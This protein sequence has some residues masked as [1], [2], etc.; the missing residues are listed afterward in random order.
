MMFRG[1]AILTAMFAALS[2]EPAQ[3]D[4][5]LDARLRS[6]TQQLLNALATGDRRPWSEYLD[7]RGAFTDENGARFGK[8]EMVAQVTPLPHG[9]SGHIDI[10][11]WRL[12]RWGDV[13]VDTHVDDEFEDFHGQKLHAAYRVTD[14]WVREPVG[15]RLIASQTIAVQQDPPQAA[16]PDKVLQSYVGRYA[17][18]SDYVYEISREG[19]G[20]VGRTNG[21]K[22][23][24]LRP[25]LEDVLFTPGQPRV[26]KIFQRDGA[27]RVTGFV[28]RREERDVAFK[29][30]DVAAQSPIPKGLAEGVF[31]ESCRSRFM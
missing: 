18:G 26:R 15:W 10:V 13:A 1:S 11:D 7:S 29:R 24:A 19:S 12:T 14:T 31:P 21:G 5:G 16:L 17:A 22:P 3:L 20:L 6:Q 8:D 9:V 27:G 28:S 2:A 23:Q 30:L 4:D 25:E